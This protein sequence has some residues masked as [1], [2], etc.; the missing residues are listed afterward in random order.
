MIRRALHDDYWTST[1]VQRKITIVGD[2]LNPGFAG[3]LAQGKVAA[4][5]RL[6]RAQ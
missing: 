3:D 1:G 2:P 5:L 6:V 4:D